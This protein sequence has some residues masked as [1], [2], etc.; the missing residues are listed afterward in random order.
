[1]GL[2]LLV[3]VPTTCDHR[4]HFTDTRLR[5][6]IQCLS[7]LGRPFLRAEETCQVDAGSISPANISVSNL[8]ELKDNVY[9]RKSSIKKK[10]NT[11]ITPA[12]FQVPACWGVFG[13]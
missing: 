1:M 7:P 10:K 9:L 4:R 13:F 3:L 5:G 8:G 12:S 11:P 2:D 6:K